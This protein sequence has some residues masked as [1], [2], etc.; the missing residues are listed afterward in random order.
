MSRLDLSPEALEMVQAILR[1][2]LPG[3][4]VRVFGSR[5]TG[6]SR[7]FSDLDLVVMGEEPL[8]GSLS[9]SLAEAFRES[10]LPFKV[11]VLDWAQI[12][13]EFRQVISEKSQTLQR[14]D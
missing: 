7:R 13:P 10:D 6:R 12:G 5:V 4:E 8:A 9:S 14:A 1:R 2:H 3:R 11:D